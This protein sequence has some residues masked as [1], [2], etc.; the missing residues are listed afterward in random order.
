MYENIKDK[1]KKS[2]IAN[3]FPLQ[4]QSK[5]RPAFQITD[6]RP[7][8]VTQRM[9]RET[10]GLSSVSGIFSI[11]EISRIPENVGISE[12]VNKQSG[13][14]MQFRLPSKDILRPLL[15]SRIVGKFLVDGYEISTEVPPDRKAHADGLRLLLWRQM[16][17]LQLKTNFSS[18]QDA[19]WKKLKLYNPASGQVSIE[20]ILTKGD[21]MDLE[22]L[23]EAI[24][25]AVEETQLG[26]PEGYLAPPSNSK[27][28]SNIELLVD[29]VSALF[30]KV[31]GD[32]SVL[33][34]VFGASYVST[35]KSKLQ[36]GKEKM[37]LLKKDKKIIT[38]RS[39]FS[40]EVNLGGMSTPGINILLPSTAIDAPD[41]FISQ[42]TLLHE[43][44]HAG[45]PDV[46]DAGG[47]VGSPGFKI[48]SSAVKLAN[49][50][51]YEVLAWKQA[52]PENPLWSGVFE[53]PGEIRK[54]GGTVLE[55]YQTEK[56][57]GDIY[58]IFR[59]AW[60]MGLWLY[61][62]FLDVYKSPALWEQIHS[63]GCA[64]RDFLPYWSKV[65]C[66][67]LHER[68]PDPTSSDKAKAPVSQVDLALLESFTRRMNMAMQWLPKTEAEA[69]KISSVYH[70][71][72]CVE[73]VFRPEDERDV[74]LKHMINLLNIS[75]NPGR[76]LKAVTQ[77]SE[78][79]FNDIFRKYN[80]AAF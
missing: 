41:L 34:E 53:V 15:D 72:G 78:C 80:P 4:K 12:Q 60:T 33:G 46:L 56:A 48:Q 62:T 44:M 69:W 57:L 66:L 18:L 40:K 58:E 35:A 67:T 22:N 10:A 7:E 24:T 39:G 38:D 47:Y 16:Q 49:A 29:R 79:C 1:E 55:P 25:T 11:P 26:T 37:I 76:D 45:N 61:Q 52:T 77:L 51:H 8:S 27:E 74:L 14:P 50:A 65:T 75:G 19:I 64:Y 63:N 42:T 3:S 43:A 13:L 21:H 20:N 70:G 17:E 68:T 5:K 30:D 36:K 71:K 2:P 32:D 23:A 73:Y 59:K 54:D 31:W 9:L 6:N 28:T